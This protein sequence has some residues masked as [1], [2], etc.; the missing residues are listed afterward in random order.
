MNLSKTTFSL[1]LLGTLGL[2]L[3]PALAA[4]APAPATGPGM[5]GAGPTGAGPMGG[6]P[7]AMQKGRWLKEAPVPMLMPIVFR[8]MAELN[9]SAEQKKA[10]EDWRTHQVAQGQKWRGSML[11]HN[12]AL[13]D[14]LLKGETGEAL[15]PLKAAVDKDHREMLEHGIRQVE[16]LHHTLTPE[17]W[18]KVTTLYTQMG[19]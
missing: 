7:R 1:L 11:E 4:A 12:R 13:R 9:L 8:H 14:A 3:A 16:F 5:M 17:Q 2:G 10:L 6:G 15:A 18:E 19:R